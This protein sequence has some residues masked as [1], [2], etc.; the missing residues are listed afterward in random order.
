MSTYRTL[1]GLVAAGLLLGLLGTGCQSQE[2]VLLRTGSVDTTRILK[3]DDEYQ[4]LAQDY[5]RERVILADQLN[6]AVEAQ[7]GALRDQATFDKFRSLEQELY[8]KWLDKTREF[9][10]SRMV[11]IGAAAEAVA[12]KKGLDL[13]V[14]DSK[15]FPTVEYGGVDITGDILGEIPGLAGGSAEPAPATPS[16]EA[17]R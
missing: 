11:K 3:F 2:P 14:L 10:R 9:T 12:R 15:E 8:K 5:F 16:P 1:P 7:G 4:N 13:V 6:K 17:T